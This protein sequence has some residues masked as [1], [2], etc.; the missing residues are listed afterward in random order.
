MINQTLNIS[1]NRKTEKY[2]RKEQL[3]RVLWGLFSPLFHFSPRPFFCWRRVF[4][5]LF[6]SKIGKHVHVYSSATIYMPWNLEVGDWS[7]IGEH[8]YIYNL[9]RVRIGKKATISHRAHI[10]AGTHDYTYPDLP[11]RKPPITILD[12]AW[13][14][15]D[16]FVG[17]GVVVGEGAVVGARAVVT[18]DVPAWTVV[19]GN[20]AHFVKQRIIEH[21]E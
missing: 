6:G 20:P 12:Q 2:S 8:A 3:M 10:C 15:A 21:K 5:R 17:P 1:A 16:A 14:C 9:G 18:K 11:L 13:L 4:L 19:A 7:S